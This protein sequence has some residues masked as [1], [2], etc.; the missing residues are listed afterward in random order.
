M[1]N[2]NSIIILCKNIKLDKEH[3]NV[4][5]YTEQEMVT[6]CYQNEISHASNYSF[7]KEDKGE[8]DV[9]FTYSECLQANYMAFQNPS[10]N[11]KWFFAFVD[12]VEYKSNLST[13]IYYTIDQ[14]ATWFDYWNPSPCFVLREHTNDD[15][16]GLNTVSEGLD[17]GEYIINL[18]G[19]VETRLENCFMCVGVTWLPD[20][21][22]F[23]TENRYYGGVYSG[24]SYIL[25]KDGT[26]TGKFIRAIDEIGRNSTSTI[27]N[28]FP[29]P[30]I[31]T[32]L[33]EGENRWVEGASLGNESGITFAILPNI[34]YQTLRNDITLSVNNT[35]NGYTPKN[36]KLFVYPFNYLMISNNAGINAEF[37]YEDFINN[38]PIFSLVGTVTPSCSI[39]LYPN[40][41]K[42]NTDGGYNYGLPVAKYPQGS[43]NNDNYTNWLTSNGINLFGHRIDAP[44]SHVIGGSLQA[45]LGGATGDYAGIGA[46][47]GA[48]FGAVQES[49]R[50]SMIPNTVSGQVNSGDITYAYNQMSPCYYKMSI[51]REMA[52]KIDDWFTRFGYKTNR[53]KLPNQ[54]GRENFN[55]VQIGNT[56]NIG[57]SVYGV[58]SEA[59]NYINALYRR[60][61]TLWHNHNNLGN[62]NV[63]NNII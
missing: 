42:L 53:I 54:T 40:N 49:Y 45:L 37:H 28:I 55:F 62:Y 38:T 63:S 46:G 16:I 6:L 51:R 1:N 22:P 14:F 19:S 12:R 56:E 15:T 47:L 27:V 44:T 43:W 21:T 11:N 32:G 17:L 36:N 41:Y 7:V 29:I 9:S 30:Q 58:P 25:F 4:L 34:N 20:N 26:S 8:I 59:M 10:Y 61:L 5:T 2:K 13:R 39:W 18:S 50:A 48:M 31:L 3:N 57:Y 33:T 35:L 23:Y 24:L 52:E 60:G